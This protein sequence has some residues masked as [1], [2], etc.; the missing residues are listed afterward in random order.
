MNNT[1]DLN[2]DLGE[3]FGAWTLGDDAG[4]LPHVSS[5]NIA[6]GFHA[7]DPQTMRHSVALCLT[8]GV[9]IGAQPGWPD[10]VGFGR[11]TLAASPAETYALVLYQISALAGF[12]RAAGSHLAHV[13]PHGALY[14]QA[15]RDPALADAIARAVADFD[16]R[17]VL[18]G[19]AGSALITAGQRAGLVVAREAF[20]DRRYLDDGSLQSRREP[21]AVLEDV[22][23]AVVQ[24]VSIAAGGEVTTA[25][26]A[27]L[28]I[29]ADT[30]CVHGD[31]PQAA[32]FAQALRQALE[33]H[34]MAVRAPRP[35]A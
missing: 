13:K 21:G 19:L 7:G 25:T 30:L 15:A 6:C 8:N 28:R 12:A 27:T 18:F 32:R 17:L 2:C 35:H 34:G 22:D 24:A 33:Q 3:S 1:L 20:A 14:N 23:A 16:P 4:V 11:R 26:G 10:L 5:A 29:A 9:A 31:R